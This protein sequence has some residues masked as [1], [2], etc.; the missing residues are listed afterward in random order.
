MSQRISLTRLIALNWYGFRQIFDVEDNVLISG[1]FGTG[2]SVLLDLMQYVL[3]GEHWRANRAAAGNAR[4]RD[5]VG[6]CLGDTNMFRNGQRHFLRTSGVTLVALEFTRPAERKS[7][8]AKRETWG[9]RL[10]YSSPEAAPKPTYFCVPDRLEYAALAPDGKLL[11]EDAF[12]TWLR[13]EYGNESL[14]ARQRDYLEEMAAPR[15]LNFDLTAFQRTFPKA[16]AFEPEENVGRFIRE[17]I[18]EES[19]LDVREVRAALRAYDDTRKR[20]EQQEDEAAHL[21][22]IQEQH[23]I[24]ESSRREEGILRQVGRMLKHQQIED[25]RDQHQTELK[26][27]EAAHAEDLQAI[28]Q[29]TAERAELDQLLDQVRFEAS[30]DPDA[31]RVQQ[32]ESE[33]RTLDQRVTALREAR[34]GIQRRLDDRH[35]RWSAWLKH[36]ASLPA[37]GLAALLPTDSPWLGQLRSGTDAER[38]EA[39]PKLATLFNTLWVEVEQL[40]QPWR[41]E[42]ADGE[43]RQRQLATD[44]EHLSRGQTPG[45]FPVFQAIRQKLGD[46]VEQLGRLIEVRP[47]SER[48]WPVLEPVLGRHRWSILPQDAAAY[49]EAWEIARKTPPGRETEVVLNPDEIA[50]LSPVA[51]SPSL[52]QHVDVSSPLARTFVDHLLGPIQTVESV[53]ELEATPA[54]QAITA[55]GHSKD[56]PGRVRLRLAGSEELTLGREGLERMRAAKRREQQ[57]LQLRLDVARQRLG[58]VQT[59]LDQGRRTELGDATL[60]DRSGELALLPQWESDLNRLRETVALLMTPERQARLDRLRD[61]EERR[62]NLD[63]RLGSLLRAKEELG[64]RSQPHREALVQLEEELRSSRL[65]VEAGRVELS[66]FVSGVLD[67]DLFEQ[68]DTLRKQFPKWSDCLEAVQ[69]RAEHAGRLS[70]TARLQRNAERE[71]LATARDDHG[72]LRHPAYQHEFPV[73]DERNELWSARLQLLETVELVKSRELATDRKREWERRLEDNVLNELNRRITDAQNTIRLLDRHL[74]QPVGRFRYRLSQRRDLAGYAGLWRLLDSGLEPTD[75]LAAAIQQGEVQQAKQELMRAIDASAEGDERARRLLDYRNYHHY[76]L[77]MVPA[78][79]PDAPPIS[80]GRSGRNLSGGENQAPFFIS[81]LAAFRRVYDRGDRS[82]TRSQQLGLVIMD[83][84]FSKLSGDGIEDCLALAKV[85]QLQLIMAFPP[86]RLGV[87]VPH[88][89]TVVMCQKEVERDAE[90]YVTRIDNIPLL[91]TMAEALEALT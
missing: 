40:V 39:L 80:L 57:E 49:H 54:R 11:S 59:W 18:L 91:T 79:K 1:A 33:R 10:E 75:P 85:F 17:F 20:L 82:S 74:S 37:E 88:A 55:D 72:A 62:T 30:R 13:R 78:D 38:L 25:R 89:Q 22:R 7:G 58:D 27:L 12:R 60:P 28:E 26:R 35:Q 29:A 14:F 77:E 32:L 47:E 84:A 90:G 69:T 61:L 19:P 2:K 36:G 23:Q 6:Y 86:E 53:G 15:H 24:Y 16:I 21:R 87:M 8:E 45:S 43:S 42:F 67:V 66:R 5:L 4:G 34:L 50:S 46:R 3:L 71:R 83:E 81:M 65:Q 9:I 56:V 73:D 48:W 44:L 52:R 63:R 76:D 41:R 31:G 68:R 70:D 51:V 64:L